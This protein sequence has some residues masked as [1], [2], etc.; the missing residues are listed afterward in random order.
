MSTTTR[1][2]NAD[3]QQVWAVLS[4]GWSY[5]DWVVGTVHIRDV[6]P[7]WPAVGTR[8]HHKAGPWP[9]SLKDSSTVLSCE[10][11]RDLLLKVRLWPLGA[12]TV[13]ITLQEVG[14]RATRVTMVEEFTDGP[15][16][17]VRNALG[18]TLLHYRNREALRRLE[19]LAVGHTSDASTPVAVRSGRS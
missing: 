12:G 16:L 7:D 4:N 13:R 6:A 11:G 2:M 14:P 9:F 19:D 1:L 5:S 15:M 17:G 3:P 18:D 8:I 10:P